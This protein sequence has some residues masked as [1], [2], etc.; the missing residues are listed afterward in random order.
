ME[1]MNKNEKSK[2]C[3]G[4]SNIVMLDQLNHFNITQILESGQVFRYE[5]ISEHSYLL[6]AK[7]K[8]K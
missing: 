4:M 6:N 5:K 1:I 7:L 3:G 8:L 2:G